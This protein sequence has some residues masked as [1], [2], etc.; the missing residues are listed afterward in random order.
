MRDSPN[1]KDQSLESGMLEPR[2]HLRRNLA[3]EVRR[4]DEEEERIDRVHVV[5]ID[6]DDEYRDVASVGLAHFGFDVFICSD[7]SALMEH[8]ERGLH[9]DVIVLNWKIEVVLGIDLLSKLR[10]CGAK[11][12]VVFLTSSPAAAY[13]YVALDRGAADFVDKARGIPVLAKRLDLVVNILTNHAVNNR[14]IK[15]FGGEQLRP[16]LH[17][18]D[19]CSAVELLLSVPAAK[20]QNETFNVGFQNL[21]IKEISLLVKST[22]EEIYPERPPVDI[23]TTP[24]DDNRSYHINSDKIKNQLGFVP[25]FTIED[26][27]RDL[28]LAFRQEKILGS[29][30]DDWYYNIRTMKRLNAK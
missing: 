22:V 18:K 13:E 24:S 27:V 17:V 23:V 11:A 9:A 12:P 21:S 30:D 29:M 15:V 3:P 28:A 4:E 14:K 10:R 16:N 6:D 25:Q 7:G 2:E 8:L 20:I 5:L 1:S 19:Y 26:A